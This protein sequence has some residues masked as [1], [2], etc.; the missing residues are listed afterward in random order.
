M[1]KNNNIT[2]INNIHNQCAIIVTQL[3]SVIRK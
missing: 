2:N 3:Q 1:N